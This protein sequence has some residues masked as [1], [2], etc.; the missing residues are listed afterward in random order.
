TEPQRQ[1]IIAEMAKI[2][3]KEPAEVAAM[4]EGLA[5]KQTPKGETGDLFAQP[6]AVVEPKPEAP[7][8]PA[9]A[10]IK[11]SARAKQALDVLRQGGYCRKRRGRNFK[12]GETFKT[13]LRD[14]SGNVVP[15]IGFQTREELAA[16]GML[17]RRDV[18]RSSVW[19]EEWGLNP[20]HAQ[21]AAEAPRAEGKPDPRYGGMTAEE[22]ATVA[23]RHG[24]DYADAL[25][26]IRA[27]PSAWVKVVQDW[28][29]AEKA[30]Q[31]IEQKAKRDADWKPN[32]AQQSVL[33]LV[34]D[35]GRF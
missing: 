5:P 22:M 24:H 17:V 21:S 15:G 4:F 35:T 13:R 10:P 30:E 9:A 2:G 7:K 20:E 27:R 32:E 6:A 19:P 23:S 1:R 25:A 31:R 26:K 12:G 33:I 11:L 3:G 28:I 14:A 16:A 29:E 8:K 34:R 18:P